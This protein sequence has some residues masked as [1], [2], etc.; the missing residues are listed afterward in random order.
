M[1]KEAPQS[2]SGDTYSSMLLKKKKNQTQ[3]TIW[4][5]KASSPPNTYT[6]VDFRWTKDLNVESKPVLQ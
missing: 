4:N 6:E 2:N 3:L 5:N 1:F